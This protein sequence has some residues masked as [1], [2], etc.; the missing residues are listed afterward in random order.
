MNGEED[1]LMFAEAA[2]ASAVTERQLSSIAGL[3]RDLSSTLQRLQPRIVFTC[4][5]GS[6][7]HAAT[8]AKYLIE[9]QLKI[10]TVSQAPSFSSIYGGTM[11]HMKDQPFIL[12]SQSGRS[13]DLLASAQSAR[14]AGALVIVLVNDTASPLA[15]LAHVVVPLMAG[16]EKSVAATKSFI[17]SIAAIVNL[18]G[19]WADDADLQHACAMLPGT[20]HDA[21]LA[22]WSQG[23]ELFA[24]V[25]NMFVLGRSLTLGIAQ[26]AALKFKETSG[27]HAEAFSLAEVAH[28]PAALIKQGFPILI[29]APP[30]KSAAGL[31]ATVGRFVSQGA[32]IAIAGAN[33]MDALPLP[34][35]K[36]LHPVIAPIAMIQSFYRMI[37]AVSIMRGYDPDNPAMLQKVT[38]TR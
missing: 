37:N 36:N 2:Q 13:P 22:D 34:V 26:E 30:G 3:I 5:R 32:D 17:A 14:K 8:F 6:S 35:G 12:I 10:P 1:T 11:A 38:E 15:K 27:I 33:K 18:V 9:T 4:A 23:A 28:G 24:R 31:K 29:F 25:P 21:W 20:L 16:P 7:D 19:W